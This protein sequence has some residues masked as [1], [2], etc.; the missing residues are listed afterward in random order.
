MEIQ[1]F[2]GAGNIRF[3]LTEAEAIELLG[4]PSERKAESYVEGS[5]N[6]IEVLVTFEDAGM[7]LNFSAEDDYRL[8]TIT[9]T[10]S[11]YTL[12]GVNYI[13]RSESFLLDLHSKNGL[14]DLRLDDDFDFIEAKDY[15]SDVHGLSFW[16]EEGM[17]VSITIMPRF[18]EDGDTILWPVVE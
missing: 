14:A 11:S 13:G 8:T 3:G 4:E 17:V 16:I 1:P 15:C 6:D 5:E 7:D 10:D 9:F 12:F 2:V 18:S